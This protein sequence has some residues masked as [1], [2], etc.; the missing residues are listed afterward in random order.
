MSR[1]RFEPCVESYRETSSGYRF[2]NL[3]AGLHPAIGFK[4]PRES[5]AINFTGPFVFD[6]DN[7]VRTVRDQAWNEA[8]KPRELVSV[9]RL[10]D[11]IVQAGPSGSSEKTAVSE[12]VEEQERLPKTS[13]LRE[14]ANKTTAAFVLDYLAQNGYDASLSRLRHAM[15]RRTW[16]L[17]PSTLTSKS[18]GSKANPARLVD[19]SSAAAALNHLYNQILNPKSP[20]PWSLIYSFVPSRHSISESLSNRLRIHEFIRHLRRADELPEPEAE[21]IDQEAIDLGKTLLGRSKEESWAKEDR[22]LLD[23]AF[24]LIGISVGAWD[25]G[26]RSVAGE[27]RRRI[28]ADELIASIQGEL[29]PCFI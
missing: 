7:Y 6:I 14:P 27:E 9:P 12:K 23:Q 26:P 15:M 10:C 24:G 11:Q 21:V 2:R 16:L 5:I 20:I 1:S 3:Q 13:P 8:T 25:V 29:Y 4:T 19:F 22:T 28:D 17:P 18:I